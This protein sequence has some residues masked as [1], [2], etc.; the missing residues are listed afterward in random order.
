MKEIIL[1]EERLLELLSLTGPGGV[2]EHRYLYHLLKQLHLMGYTW[3]D[4][5]KVTL[6]N[7]DHEPEI[8]EVYAEY[9]DLLA[10]N[11]SVSFNAETGEIKH[12]PRTP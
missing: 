12:D 8:S 1:D 10:E 7:G 2:I 9:C 11:Q 5:W 3:R 6:C 4:E